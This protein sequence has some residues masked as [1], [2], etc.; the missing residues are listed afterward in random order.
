MRQRTWPA[1]AWEEP[2]VKLR[3]EPTPRWSSHLTVPALVALAW[4]A[5]IIAGQAVQAATGREVVLCWFHRVTGLACPTCGGT[6]MAAAIMSGDWTTAA[7]M[8]PLL[9]V[10][11]AWLLV[12]ATLRF[13]CGRRIVI[14][15]H[16][17]WRRIGWS[18][19]AAALV[20]NWLYLIAAG[21]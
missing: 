5:L 20:A 19:L 7:A 13:A 16:P 17:H 9:L 15:L 14:Q 18:L 4:V 3:L 8:N 11:L 2:V 1:A 10:V 6:R 21:R 12:W